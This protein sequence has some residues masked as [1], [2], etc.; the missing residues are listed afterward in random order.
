MPLYVD[1]KA[2]TDMEAHAERTFLRSAA[3]RCW[4]VTSKMGGAKSLRPSQ[5]KHKRR[6]PRT[7]LL[8]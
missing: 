7:P 3:A 1:E 5:S 8:D 6:K 2:K 4:A